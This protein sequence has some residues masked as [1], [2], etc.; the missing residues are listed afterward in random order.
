MPRMM[1]KP[2]VPASVASLWHIAPRW[3][4]LQSSRGTLES[5]SGR[6]G[7]CRSLNRQDRRKVEEA[8]GCVCSL[9]SQSEEQGPLATSDNP[10]CW[11]YL[12]LWKFLEANHGAG[13]AGRGM[14]PILRGCQ[15]TVGRVTHGVLHKPIRP[16]SKSCFLIALVCRRTPCDGDL[17]STAH[18]GSTAALPTPPGLLGASYKAC[19]QHIRPSHRDR[20][21]A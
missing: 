7:G 13:R 14:S 1:P 6:W 5:K 17:A 19:I 20:R 21:L 12:D 18:S 15:L 16:L 11:H 10:G 3:N 8:N 4:P 9:W 2:S